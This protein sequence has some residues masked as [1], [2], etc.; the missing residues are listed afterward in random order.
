MM[1]KTTKRLTAAILTIVML[2]T[3]IFAIL[4]YIPKKNA[5]AAFAPDGYTKAKFT[6]IYNNANA[7][8]GVSA[9]AD[10][11]V[12]MHAYAGKASNWA[13]GDGGICGN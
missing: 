3:A 9:T 12:L 7:N 13:D 4:F 2:A 8:T 10:I 11:T 6:N 1:T 5:Y